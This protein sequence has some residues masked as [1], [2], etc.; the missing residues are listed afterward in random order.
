MTDGLQSSLAKLVADTRGQL[1][2]YSNALKS[3]KEPSNKLSFNGEV[4][5]PSFIDLGN[6]EAAFNKDKTSIRTIV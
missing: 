2:N 5:E 6:I 3:D 1:D 4:K